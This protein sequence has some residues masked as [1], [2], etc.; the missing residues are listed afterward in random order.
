YE[1]FTPFGSTSYQASRTEMPKRY[2]YTGRER[3]DES[4]F[5]IHGA[6]Y[7][8]TWLARWVSADPAGLIDGPFLYAYCGNAPTPFVDTAGT[9]STPP[10]GMI[11]NDA[12]IGA[13]WEQAVVDALGPRLSLPK[14]ATYADTIKAFQA[15]VKKMPPGSNRAAGTGMNYARESYKAA[16][17]RF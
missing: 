6:R 2:R 13:L 15:K 4:G 11:G 12:R 10:P 7:Y 5:N 8:A 14:T 1:E 9:Q 3:D 17:S 16:R